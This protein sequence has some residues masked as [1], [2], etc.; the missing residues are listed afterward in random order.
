MIIDQ[1]TKKNYYILNTINKNNTTAKI[2][3]YLSINN[4]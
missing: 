1:L 4:I 3:T 2:T